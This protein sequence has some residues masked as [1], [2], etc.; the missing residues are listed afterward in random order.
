MHALHAAFL[1]KGVGRSTAKDASSMKARD[2]S[3]ARTKRK[4]QRLQQAGPPMKSPGSDKDT[5]DSEGLHR[6]KK[7]KVDK[8]KA[9]AL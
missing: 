7:A 1:T 5:S 9:R 3:E 8:G 2:K 4:L 6:A